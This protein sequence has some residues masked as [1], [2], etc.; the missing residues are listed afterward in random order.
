MSFLSSPEFL[1]RPYDPAERVLIL[2][3]IARESEPDPQEY[4]A[5]LDRLSS[6]EATWETTVRDMF[7]SPGFAAAIPR[8]CSGQPFGMNARAPVIVV[9]T[10]VNGSA[11]PGGTGADLQQLLDAAA[12]GEAV[13]LAQ[14]AVVWVKEQL[15]VPSGVTL[16][17]IG[18]PKPDRYASMARLVRT[19]TNRQPM[20]ALAPGATLSN[21]WVDGQ[22]SSQSVGMDHDSINVAVLGGRE[23]SLRD[24]RITN[25]AGWSNVVVYNN[26]PGGSKC[27]DV[28][29]RGNLID[30]YSSKFHWHETTGVVDDR[31]DT[32]TVTG[33]VEN[34]RNGQPGVMSTFGFADGIS[35]QCWDSRIADN[36][37]VD[38]T[39]VSIV[40]FG[41]PG[42]KDL[43]HARAQH[44][45]AED[46]TIVGAGNSG[47]AAMTMD[48]LYPAEAF[49]DFE[50]ATMRRNLVWTSPNA[51]LL[52]VAGVGTEPW[53]GQNTASGYGT[54]RFVDNTSGDGRINTQMAIAVS[55]MPGAIV[56]GN[57]LLANLALAT[58]CPNGPYIGVDESEGA[59][60]QEPNDPVDFPSFPTPPPSQGCLVMHF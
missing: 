8:L 44:S 57:T 1:D 20:V 38:I 29:I 42:A 13:L 40:F 47:W 37:F 51:F 14:R 32:G 16:K 23:T 58:L 26:P 10:S 12:P 45:V 17:T 59:D 9:P 49:S 22:R 33:Q 28:S 50:G 15:T 18:A 55:Q 41:A 35:N 52:L 3:R 36:Q 24:S 5:A 34:V 7:D 25:T 2:W 60:V 19:E 4:A 39:D 6:G 54:A 11:F 53:F 46:N 43:S 31:V 56:Q 30:G 48:Q 21:V 27:E